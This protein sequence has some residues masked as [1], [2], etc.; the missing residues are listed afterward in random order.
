VSKT[1]FVRIFARTVAVFDNSHDVVVARM[2][3]AARELPVLDAAR[4]HDWSVWASIGD[5][6]FDLDSCTDV[7]RAAI[8]TALARARAAIEAHGDIVQSDLAG[9]SVLPGHNVSSGYLRCERLPV[10]AVLDAVDGF[11]EML[12]NRLAPDPP[13]GLWVLGYSEGRGQLTRRR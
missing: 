6:G 5:L 13:D 7:E 8:G 12:A 4:V 9:W 2:V 10:A 1:K 3:E 11:E